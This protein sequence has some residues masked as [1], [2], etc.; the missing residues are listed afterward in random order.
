MIELVNSRDYESIRVRPEVDDMGK[1]CT[2]EFLLVSKMFHKLGR[3][4]HYRCLIV[5]TP[6][7]L[8]H[9]ADLIV[10]EPSLGAH[11]QCLY[12]YLAQA[13]G[14]SLQNL[15][16]HTT[17][18]RRILPAANNGSRGPERNWS[19]LTYWALAALASSAGN[20]L[21]P[22][23][24]RLCIQ[25][26]DKLEWSPPPPLEFDPTTVPHDALAKLETLE[27]SSLMTLSF[28]DSLPALRHVQFTRAGKILGQT[29]FLETHGGKLLTLETD[30]ACEVFAHCPALREL[31]ARHEIKKGFKAIW[32][33][34]AERMLQWNVKMKDKDGKHW[35][36]C[37]K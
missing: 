1:E 25:S 15:L 2:F 33:T 5:H 14:V 29:E 30:T 17:Q 19:V 26:T 35:M 36:P 10:S 32:A 18:L 37:L 7:Q 34:W 6:A 23:G 27:C 20:A 8:T 28:L 4:H 13:C 12:L 22:A 11:I 24:P 16:S 3:P 9:Y 31:V 21:P